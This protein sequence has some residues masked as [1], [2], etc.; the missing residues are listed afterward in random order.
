M[1]K[2]LYPRG[3]APPPPPLAE[4]NLPGVPLYARGKVREMYDLGDRL[5]MVATDRISAFDVVMR[6]P[7]PG[8]GLV[9][10]ALSEFWFR[11]T[12]HLVPNHLL[13]SDVA[14]LPAEVRQHARLL[15]GRSLLVR[16]ARRVDIEC[17]VRG[18]LAGSAW[19]EYR[20]RGTMAGEP[21]PPGLVESQQL[22]E[23]LFTPATKAESGHD[24][25]ITVARMRELV[26]GELAE[27][28]R[29]ASLQLY[30]Y[31]EAHARQRGI[32]L[33]DTKFEFGL[34]DGQVILIDEALT[35]DSSRFWPAD[36]YCPGQAQPSFDKQYLR[37]YLEQSGWNKEPPPPPL[38]PE[39]VQR[40][41]EKYREAYV[42]LV[43]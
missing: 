17:V 21:L 9:L 2:L 43:S 1:P 4:L 41:A 25:N 32:I 22:P 11:A 31:A 24:E 18:Y 6:E 42:R 27:Q 19:A 7:V 10:T 14:D 12:S 40:T 30:Q 28:L 33:A 13:G 23:P 37:D 3:D 15:E 5:L 8:K 29:R 26:G 39:V 20:R 38:P 16:K 35:P 36:T 34:V